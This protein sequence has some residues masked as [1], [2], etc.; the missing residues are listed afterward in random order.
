MHIKICGITDIGDALLCQQLGADAIGFI[1]FKGSRRY[2]PPLKAKEIAERTSPLLMKVGVFVNEAAE[3]INH[4]AR[5]CNLNS[6]QLHGEETPGQAGQI[7]SPVIKVFRIHLGFDFSEIN[8][9]QNCGILLDSYSADTQGGSGK[10]FDWELIPQQLRKRCILSGGISE[11]NLPRI[12][13]SFQ[14][15]GIDL[16]SAV[17]SSPGKKDPEKLKSFFKQLE[18]LK[19]TNHGL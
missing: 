2:I 10:V 12:V 6:V 18:K 5:F 15:A 16:S 17:E 13:N 4:L 14:P 3:T 1:F 9:F 7:Q 19:P 8:A 11:T